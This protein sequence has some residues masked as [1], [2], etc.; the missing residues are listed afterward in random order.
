MSDRSQEDLQDFKSPGT[1]L[2]KV[3]RYY[4]HLGPLFEELTDR[5]GFM[6]LGYIEKGHRTRSI[7]EA[8][9]R[10]IR[11]A[12]D[13]GRFRKGMRVLDVGCGLGGPGRMVADEYQCHVVGIDPGQYQ[14]DS[15]RRGKGNPFQPFGFEPVA[16]D[17]MNQPFRSNS[18][19][20]VYSIESAFHYPDKTV[21]VMESA[22]LLKR[23]GLLVVADILPKSEKSGSWLSSRFLTALEA[24]QRY[25]LE[26]YKLAADR[27]GLTLIRFTDVSEG[28]RRVFPIWKNVF[29]NKWSVNAKRYSIGTLIKI[30]AALIFAS[31]FSKSVPLR[32]L[33]MVFGFKRN[34]TE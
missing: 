2:R 17:A 22:R 13:E 18:F 21:F 26:S 16:A 5:S 14:R 4:S 24:P 23:D 27:A 19:D 8:Q 11:M 12:A 31:W 10:L 32:Y 30:G 1:R 28:V 25:T 6:N 7:I 33:I 15:L 3:I 9:K 29:F 34:S 20:R